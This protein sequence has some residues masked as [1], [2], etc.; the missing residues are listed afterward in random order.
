M[1]RVTSEEACLVLLAVTFISKDH[2]LLGSSVT[3]PPPGYSQEQLLT[4]KLE[5]RLDIGCLKGQ[6][7]RRKLYATRYSD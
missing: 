2:L 3:L 6:N 7:E 5:S 4:L 1:E